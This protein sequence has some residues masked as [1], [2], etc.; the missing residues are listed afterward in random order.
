MDKKKLDALIE[1]K[2]VGIFVGGAS[3]T[4][5]FIHVESELTAA[6]VYDMD[7]GFFE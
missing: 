4:F 7:D 5:I 1:F 3:D 6:A 2:V